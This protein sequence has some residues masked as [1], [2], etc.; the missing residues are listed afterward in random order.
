MRNQLQQEAILDLE[1]NESTSKTG[2]MNKNA[3]TIKWSRT[4]RESVRSAAG[5]V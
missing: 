5:M 3:F 1:T 2:K 4:F